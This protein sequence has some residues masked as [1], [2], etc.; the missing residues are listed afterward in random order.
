MKR[1]EED[2]WRWEVGVQEGTDG[3]KKKRNRPSSE[4]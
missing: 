2:R 4:W 3:H 1:R